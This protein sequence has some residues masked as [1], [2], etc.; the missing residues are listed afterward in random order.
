[1]KNVHNVFLLRN[2]DASVIMMN[3]NAEEEICFPQIL[4]GE[5]VMQ[6]GFNLLNLMI[7]SPCYQNVVN[8]YNEGHKVIALTDVEEAVIMIRLREAKMK[9]ILTELLVPLSRSLFEAVQG[10]V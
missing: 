1:M 8:I 5:L 6:E 10:L 4:N 9:Q 7:I 2:V 3:L